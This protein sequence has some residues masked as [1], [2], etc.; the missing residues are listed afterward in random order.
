MPAAKLPKNEAERL[1]A[2]KRLNILDTPAEEVF[3]A[4]VK[5]ASL[6]CQTPISLIS[7]V[8]TNRQ[9]FKA[10][11]G[12]P[13]VNETP[14]ELAFCAHT[15]LDNTILEVH[16]AS[17][18]PRFSDNALVTDNPNIRFYAGA[19]L[20]LSTGE[21]VGTLCVID[22][23]PKTLSVEQ[24]TALS[25]L[26]LVAS[27]ALE[28]H[29]LH[30][31]EQ[32]I[33]TAEEALLE[34]ADYTASIFHNTKE[35]I[36]AL[37]LDGTITHWNNAA[38]RLFGYS[39]EEIL[40]DHIS[41]L[42]PA[43]RLHEETDFEDRFI[44][45]PD[46][47][48]YET[49]RL[50][51]Q[52]HT[53]DVLVSV[54]PLYNGAGHLIGATKI[55]H[56][57]REQK[58]TYQLLE[59]NEA[60]YRAL[61]DASPLGVFSCDATGACT[62]TNARWQTIFGL[63]AEESLGAEWSRTIHPE[64]IDAVFTEWQRVAAARIEFDMEFRILHADNT[65]RYVRSRSRPI[66]DQQNTVTGFVGSV[67]DISERRNALERLSASEE[68]LRQLYHSTPAMLQSIDPHGRLI[69]V[70]DL[71]LKRHGYSRDEVIGRMSTE[72]MTAESAA[73]ARDVV[74]PMSMQTG[75]CEN[76][77][78]QKIT[79]S[80]EVFDVLLSS[81]I[82]K[83]ASGNPIR[84]MAV[85]IDITAE[86]AAKRAAQEL[87][88]TI[89]TQFITSITNAEGT[90]I[91]VNDAFCKI[92]QYSREE[93]IGANHRKVNSGYH[94]QAFFKHMWDTISQGNA[95]QGEICN[96]AK[97]GSL[98]W[99]N[100]IIS[101]L[102]GNDGNIER[103]ISIRTDITERKLA[104]LAIVE[105]KQQI[106]QLIENQSVAT[107]MID[108]EHRILHWNK[109][110]EL[111]TGL[112]ADEIVGKPEAWRGFYTQPRPC[113]ADLVA[114][115]LKE[116]AKNYYPSQGQSTLLKQGWHAEAWFDDLGGERRYVIFDAAPIFNS[117]GKIT[118]VIETLQD[119]TASKLAEQAL[120]EE[121]QYLASVIEGTGAGTWQWNVATGECRFN[122]TWA[123][124]IGYSLEEMG[125][126]AYQTWE[127]LVYP[128]DLPN[129]L[130]DM[131]KHFDGETALFETEFR[132]RHKEGHLVWIS[133]RGR[134][135]SWT[136][137]NKPAWMYGTH[138]DITARIQQQ[139]AIKEA[140]ERFA[141][142]TRGGGIGIWSYD[143]INDVFNGDS[144]LNKLYGLDENAVLD[145]SE[146]K[147]MI[148]PDDR[149]EEELVFNDALKNNGEYNTEFRVIWPDNSV[150]YIS[151]S[152]SIT[153][154][155]GGMVTGVTGVDWDVTKLRQLALELAEQHETLRV[156]LKS[157]GDAVITT[158]AKG[159]VTW[160]NPVAE[161]MTGWTTAEA[162]KKPLTQVFNILNEDTRKVSESPV[163]ACL[164][165]GKIVGLANHTILV[166]RDGIEY[167]IEDSA[168][169][170][171]G[172]DGKILGVVLVFHDV[173]EQRRLSSE[174]SYRASHDALTGLVNRTEFETRLTRILNSTKTGGGVHA[175]MFI[176]LDQ[177][178]LVNDACGHSAGDL[179]LQQVSKM[180]HD[181]VRSRD[182]LARLGGDEFG[183]ILEKCTPEQAQR[184]AQ[185]IC[186]R[187]DDFRFI[188][189]E[190]RFRI[191][192]SIGLT[193][194]DSRWNSVA[195][196]LQAADTACFVAKEAGRNRVHTWFDS[197]DSVRTQQGVMQWATRI[198]QAIDENQFELY[199][200]RIYPVNVDITN[201][202][203]VNIHAEI[204]IRLKDL[205]GKM[206]PPN[207]FLPAAERFHLASRIDRWVLQHVL[208]W[209]S[210]LEDLSSLHTICV[211]LSGQSIGDRAFHAL[212][213][214]LLKNAGKAICQRLCFEITET[215]TVT[216]IIDASIFID[217]VRDL[218]VRIALDD[219]GAGASSFGYLK[220]LKVDTLKIDGQ[221][222]K[223]MIR[224]AL[225]DSAVRCFVNVAGIVKV[226]TVAEYVE[227]AEIL[228]HVKNLGIDYAQGYL[229]HKPAPLRE[230]SW[231]KEGKL[232][233]S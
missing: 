160:L 23:A 112:S 83:D 82:E 146:W 9:W 159:R 98:Y 3:D 73:Y 90:I 173:T 84:G 142:A 103:Y 70:S 87:L 164:K 179:L 102:K 158:D 149:E 65:L 194:I 111:L 95:W 21:H 171:R 104:E 212:A 22:T 41:I 51:K 57:L 144:T 145:L 105:Q 156:T 77:A 4:L 16:D 35:P 37:M 230:L 229:L 71:W 183:V 62:Y 121:Q 109:A 1:E 14:R 123:E 205:D 13:N 27:H 185:S 115:N 113:L 184:V 137:D 166:S 59:N 128:E 126:H 12:I 135:L 80:G 7:L 206:I 186:D 147:K 198:E 34:A 227:N 36:I 8:D 130:E 143:V 91:E 151:S 140:N 127:Q 19:P 232:L 226:K 40:G 231:T 93:L 86:I 193:V 210:T 180:L 223:A 107:F 175:L 136:K 138:L 48:T 201:E 225:D 17:K 154:N 129:T 150:H 122:E 47:L 30:Q 117:D 5:A 2:L 60:K 196:L 134:I 219:F 118:A 50:N 68:R 66:I 139:T 29:R 167:G 53:I 69:S 54:S 152:A 92:S 214:N 44:V 153:R 33:F 209:M 172:D 170:I 94:P 15:I 131:R 72:F 120:K 100:S 208:N 24:R 218:G 155:K 18:D 49:F 157:I 165:H 42:V 76:I 124:M 169:P 197:D 55:V 174:M 97:D 178:K 56:D 64:D 203:N 108:A 67:E 221:Y 168:A 88:S 96:R 31:A 188:H 163:A 176:D 224:D 46:G 119:I 26:G 110:C 190:K 114:D 195:S 79:K 213:V 202:T 220:T 141:L 207:A 181:V 101:P 6:I 215:A 75:S 43:D 85:L 189:D 187:M 182:T 177:F 133:S 162:I 217:Q 132:M 200:Q 61:S 99:V 192:T 32:A 211:N 38:E 10:N 116:M 45:H 106:Q 11:V 58:L 28:A 74:I 52:G 63:S 191:G 20:I 161:R 25:C 89:R 228:A 222:I 81:V 199:A 125:E 39:Q 78:Y 148:H 204:L 216:N 233:S